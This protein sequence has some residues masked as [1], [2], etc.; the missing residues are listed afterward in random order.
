MPE[1]QVDRFMLKIKVGYPTKEDE[2][3]VMNK[4]AYG[5]SESIEPVLHAEDIF[6]MR[7]VIDKIHVDEKINKYIIDL[8]FATRYPHQYGIEDLD[9]LIEYGASPRASIYLNKLARVYAFLQGRGYV[10]PNDIKSIGMDVLRHRV[11]VTFEAEA[12]EKSSEDIVERIF[13]SVKVP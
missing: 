10:I 6:A 11:L 9:G 13:D 12:E 3:E 2:L 5:V 8:I 1:A 7:E 4:V